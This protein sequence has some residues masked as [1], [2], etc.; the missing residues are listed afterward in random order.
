[1]NANANTSWPDYALLVES[2]PAIQ[3]SARP[4]GSVDYVNRFGLEYLG[5]TLA[6]VTNWDWVAIVHPEDLPNVGEKWSASLETGAPYEIE[7]RFLRAKDKAWRPHRGRAIALR[8]ASGKIVHWV[9]SHIEL[10]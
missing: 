3:W 5:R 9:G 1:M 8:D 10:A 6:D 4:D 2:G 7:M